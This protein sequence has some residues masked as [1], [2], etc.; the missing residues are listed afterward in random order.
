MMKSNKTNEEMIY[1]L[2]RKLGIT[3][4]FLGYR[5]LVDAT[6]MYIETVYIKEEDVL[7]TKDIYPNVAVKRGNVTE[8]SVERNIR[9]AI[10]ACWRDNRDVIEQLS[11]YKFSRRPTNSEF[12][13]MLA[14][15]IYNE[16]K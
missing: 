6:Q 12:I 7:I 3:N 11:V 10:N 13:D 9:S 14:Y 2:I 1:D 15:Y 5:Y 16:T 4:K 8:Q